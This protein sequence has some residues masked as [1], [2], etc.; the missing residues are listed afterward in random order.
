MITG[1]KTLPK[2]EKIH[3]FTKNRKPE[4]IHEHIK[5]N[6]ENIYQI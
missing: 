6:P 5:E 2:E 3:I 4:L 1:K